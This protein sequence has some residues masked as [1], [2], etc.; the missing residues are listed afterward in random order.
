M[1]KNT[2]FSILLILIIFGTSSVFSQIENSNESILPINERSIKERIR[3]HQ[4]FI[5][6][7]G[8]L[9]GVRFEA[10]NEDLRG[11]N[12][13]GNDM[14]KA[15][16]K[17]CN[18][19][20]SMFNSKDTKLDNVEFTNCNLSFSNFNFAVISNSTFDETRLYKSD[21]ALAK[22]SQTKFIAHESERLID[23][24][25]INFNAVI[26][27]NNTYKDYS[28]KTISIENTKFENDSI[29]NCNLLSKDFRLTKGLKNV[30]FIKSNL[31]SSIF[32][33]L[34]LKKCYFNEVIANDCSFVNS[35]LISVVI[36]NQSVFNGSLFSDANLNNSYINNSKFKSCNF[37]DTDLTN[38]E[39]RICDFQ[40]AEFI[41]T[42]MAES[43]FLGSSFF[44]STFT[45]A[46]PYKTNFSGCK[47][48]DGSLCN[49]G[50][51]QRCKEI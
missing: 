50:S 20:Y 13:S 35:T 44:E 48:V 12:F 14:S 26:S 31:S 5:N 19:Q 29:I 47:W 17:N 38:S 21:M 16:F 23:T 42:K 41:T 3:L 10:E 18:L 30:K 15:T 24:L 9:K 40:Y 28:F 46:F 7:N 45:P 2:K 22:I 32:D 43:D 39:I 11:I 4:R 27:K 1:L 36:I 34:T 51:Y 6:P 25:K 33:G 37:K 8:P 49:W